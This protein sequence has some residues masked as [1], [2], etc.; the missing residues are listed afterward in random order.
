MSPRRAGYGIVTGMAH[1]RFSALAR[2]PKK[3]VALTVVAALALSACASSAP[4][5]WPTAGQAKDQLSSKFGYV[6]VP[7]EDTYRSANASLDLWISVPKDLS[8]QTEMRVAVY[9]VP[10]TKYATDIDNVFSVIAPDATAWAH[11]EEKKTATTS[12]FQENYNAEQG[13]VTVV[14]NQSAPMLVFIFDRT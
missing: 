9:N 12:S 11:E 8:L 13:L 6:F 1:S 14:W 7:Y 2:A 10:Y 3:L 4:A 5:S